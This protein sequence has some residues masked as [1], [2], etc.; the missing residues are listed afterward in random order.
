MNTTHF[1]FR[2]LEEQKMEVWTIDS[3]T[4]TFNQ[5]G[6]FNWTQPG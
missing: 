1:F 3:D 5:V 6:T 4:L 2:N